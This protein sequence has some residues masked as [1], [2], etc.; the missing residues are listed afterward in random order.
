MDNHNSTTG[1]AFVDPVKYSRNTYTTQN[2]LETINT[3]Q[4]TLETI[5]Q[6]SNKTGY[7]T[8]RP[9][10]VIILYENNKW[11]KS[12]YHLFITVSKA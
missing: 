11:E 7:K 9:K 10:L 8:N 3:P 2:I 12:K 1:R 6:Y 4:N 5:N